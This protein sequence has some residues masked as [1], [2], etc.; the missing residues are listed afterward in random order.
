MKEKLD[1]NMI[2]SA[3]YFLE[4]TE[5]LLQYNND[6]NEKLSS[7]F[8]WSISMDMNKQEYDIKKLFGEA[9]NEFI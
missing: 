3:E 8:I 1:H 5:V 2:V 4:L 7:F 6:A 9:I